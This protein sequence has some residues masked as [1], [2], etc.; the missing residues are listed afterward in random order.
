MTRKTYADFKRLASNVDIQ[1]RYIVN[2]DFITVDITFYMKQYPCCYSVTR[3]QP[4]DWSDIAKYMPYY[5]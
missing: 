2:S 4:E 3:C 5:D 1:G